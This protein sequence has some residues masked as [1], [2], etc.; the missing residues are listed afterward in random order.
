VSDE[1]RAKL[2]TRCG[3][4]VR[5]RVPHTRTD[6]KD[7]RTSGHRAVVAILER[8]HELGRG[9]S[10]VQHGALGAIPP[11]TK[12]PNETDGPGR[13]VN[14]VQANFIPVVLDLPLR[15]I[16]PIAVFRKSGSGTPN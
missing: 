2:V 1:V 5:G 12:Q 15:S 11:H 14:I 13:L 16:V 8:D 9:D 10:Q 6:G 4:R 3:F 7:D